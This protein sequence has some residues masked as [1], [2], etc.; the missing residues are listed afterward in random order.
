MNNLS[1]ADLADLKNRF[2]YHGPKGDQQER[3]EFLRATALGLAITI[4]EKVPAG[5]ERSL[6]LTNLEQSIFWANA[7]IARNE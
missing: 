5:R 6:A 1:Q 7:G 2:T 4:S 3:Y